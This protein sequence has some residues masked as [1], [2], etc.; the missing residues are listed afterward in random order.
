MGLAPERAALFIELSRQAR[1]AGRGYW[2]ARFLANALHYLEDVAQPFHASQTPTK[3]F[4][5]MPLFD[6]DHGAGTDHYVLQVQNIIAYY[7]Y[8]FENFVGREMQEHYDGEDSAAGKQF[9]EALAGESSATDN[10]ASEPGALAEQVIAMAHASV[11]VSARAATASMAFFPP[12]AERFDAFDPERAASSEAW[13]AQTMQ[14]SE[15]DSPAR[16]EYFDVVQTMFSRLGEA[17]RG[18]VSAELP[19]PPPR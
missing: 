14:K 13:W 6:R 2:S 19:E 15:V 5:F 3:R 17:V 4:L 16:R 18:V 7:H 9:V 10:S 12:I 1:A 8:A 11:R